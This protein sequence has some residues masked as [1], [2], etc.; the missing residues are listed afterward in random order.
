LDVFPENIGPM[1]SSKYPHILITQSG[2]LVF[3]STFK[4]RG[5]CFNFM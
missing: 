4:K 1:I 5:D 3:C 2:L